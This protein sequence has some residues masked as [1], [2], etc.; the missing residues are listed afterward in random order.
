M[1]I[2]FGFQ[3][4]EQNGDVKKKHEI[5]DV[6]ILLANHQQE[7]HQQVVH[8]LYQRFLHRHHHQQCHQ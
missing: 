1:K 7:Q 2:R 8:R 6:P 5:K 3:I 4:E